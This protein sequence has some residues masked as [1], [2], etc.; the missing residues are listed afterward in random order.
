[1]YLKKPLVYQIMKQWMKA[2]KIHSYSIY[3]EI[4]IIC[5]RNNKWLY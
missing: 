1:M 2:N 3:L 4:S 5:Q